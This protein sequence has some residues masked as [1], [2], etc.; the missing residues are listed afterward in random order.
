MVSGVVDA[1][2]TS[3]LTATR[4]ALTPLVPTSMPRK[5]CSPM[6]AHS[7]QQLHRQLI[8]LLVAI[9]LGA[10]RLEL[11]LLVANGLRAL[12]GVRH[13]QT[14]RR[15]ALAQLTENPLDLLVRI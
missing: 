10:Q 12:L 1:A 8:E 4:M 6:S 5:T 7:E 11:E 3:P 14:A 15:A 13:A 2:T 9:A